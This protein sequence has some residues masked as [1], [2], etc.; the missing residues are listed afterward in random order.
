M[1][2]D[3]KRALRPSTNKF[4][5]LMSVKTVQ[6]ATTSPTK[7]RLATAA[8]VITDHTQLATSRPHFANRAAWKP[9]LYARAIAAAEGAVPVVLAPAVRLLAAALISM[10]ALMSMGA[11]S[12]RRRTRWHML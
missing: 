3:V 7:L 11:I 5:A 6:L 9:R 10:I 12:V 8:Y 4:P 2:Q 1:G